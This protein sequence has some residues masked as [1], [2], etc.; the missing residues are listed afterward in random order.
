M[1]MCRRMLGDPELAEDAL[2]EACL[3]SLLSLNRLRQPDRFGVWL[4]GI[5][6]HIATARCASGHRTTG[7]LD[8]LDGGRAAPEPLDSGPDLDDIVATHE[9]LRRVHSAVAGLPS[10]QR[11]SVLLVY[12]AGFTH[13]EAAEALGIRSSAVK[14]RLHKARRHL[15]RDLLTTWEDLMTDTVPIPSD[16]TAAARR[17]RDRVRGGPHEQRWVI[18]RNRRNTRALARSQRPAEADA[19]AVALQGERLPA[20]LHD[21]FVRS[22]SEMVPWFEG[23]LSGVRLVLLDGAVVG[24]LADS[25]SS[26]LGP[27]PAGGGDG[28]SGGAGGGWQ[29][30]RRRG[31]FSGGG[32]GRRRGVQRR[33]A[34][35]AAAAPTTTS[36]K[37][38]APIPRRGTVGMAR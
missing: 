23:A 3:Q 7:S 22:I 32:G 29:R 10:T 16:P 20:W 34:V 36:R 2:Q 21:E 4:A 28:S 9:V 15:R 26:Q 37:G 18:V 17:E 19:I 11:A 14:M 5:A 31:G 8:A 35:V 13:Y 6:V 25:G 1:R 27:V 30:G 24:A 12:L 38:P 33:G